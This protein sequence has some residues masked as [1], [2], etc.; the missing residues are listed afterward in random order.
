MRL[1]RLIRIGLASLWLVAVANS[2]LPAAGPEGSADD[3]DA[4]SRAA[5]V[6]RGEI[7]FDDLKFDIEKGQPFHESM[8]TETI[9]KLDGKTVQLRGYILPSTLFTETD[10]K[11]F[12]LVRDNQECCFGPGSALYD[13]VIVNMVPGKTI[14]FTTR[15]VTVKGKFKQKPFLY[16]DGK[17]H[18]AVFHIEASEVE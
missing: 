6:A 2:S 18:F 13:S 12:V 11:E 7:T 15:P 5:A 17:T 4:K 9:E 1:P 3:Q 16:P 14:D 10:I 8:L